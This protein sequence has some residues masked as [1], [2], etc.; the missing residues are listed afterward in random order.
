MNVIITAS[1]TATNYNE[2][3][4]AI[5]TF[6]FVITE[7]VLSSD[8]AARKLGERWA[9][10]HCATIKMFHADLAKYGKG[11]IRVCNRE[12]ARYSDGLIALWDFKNPDTKHMIELA[13]E[14]DFPKVV[15]DIST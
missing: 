7:V 12:M 15:W 11:A 2:L 4:R 3:L 5:E 14:Y 8:N 9:N 10:E 1:P 13:A 6:D